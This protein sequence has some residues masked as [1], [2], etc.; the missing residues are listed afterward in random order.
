[1]TQTDLSVPHSDKSTL[2]EDLLSLRESDEKVR[3]EA[4]ERVRKHSRSAIKSAYEQYRRPVAPSGWEVDCL[5]RMEIELPDPAINCDCCICTV[6]SPGYEDLLY[7]MLDS[8]NSYGGSHGATVVV[9][10]IDGSYEALED[11]ED[12]T[13]IRCRSLE[14]LT[15]AVKGAVY[16]AARFVNANKFIS[17]EADT[18]ILGDLS[19]A[20]TLLDILSPEMLLGTRPS[21]RAER[22]RMSEFGLDVK[23]G[24]MKFITGS[25]KDD[26]TFWYNGGVVGG[27]HTA[28][29]RLD[30]TLR[31]LAP[32]SILWME[33]GPPFRDE[34][35]MNISISLMN[36]AAEMNGT[37]NQQ[38]FSTEREKW[39]QTIERADGLQYLQDGDPARILHF[40][41]LG[42]PLM[43][44]I[45]AEI[46]ES[47]VTGL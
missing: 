44:N 41:S 38:F 43:A 24:D 18:L 19:S 27:S 33:S 36:N 30:D 47:G 45:K 11:R 9:F 25:K 12:L 20:W 7:G 23:H 21:F 5:D 15:P 32:Y 46:A 39:I 29:M 40:I 10:A 31:T 8:L 2:R 4:F 13:R 28:F 3:F 22:P 1:M 16:S 37:F 42:R 6:I 35:L 14:R 26:G 34:L 17:V